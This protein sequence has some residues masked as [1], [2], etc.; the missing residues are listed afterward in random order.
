MSSSPYSKHVHLRTQME[1]AV[2]RLREIGS[3]DLADAVEEALSPNG[4]G[5]LRSS[6]PGGDRA[7]PNMPVRMDARIREHVKKAVMKDGTTVTAKV[8]EGLRLFIDGKFMPE[9]PERAPRGGGGEGGNLNTRPD[10]HLKKRADEIGEM[11]SGAQGWKIRA[12]AVA[13]A[14]LLEL[15]PPP[16][17]FF[18]QSADC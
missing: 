17:A 10:P 4:W 16:K 12:S 9:K 1:R 15:Y 6:S 3:H 5:L 8:N 13:R 2:E 7:A 11:M 18:Q 14:Y